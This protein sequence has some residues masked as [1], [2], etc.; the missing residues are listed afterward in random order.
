MGC[1]GGWET[2]PRL[3]PALHLNSTL[4]LAGVAESVTVTGESP[5]IDVKQNAAFATIQREA[6]E[7]MPKGRDFATI[8]R[9]APGAQSETKAGNCGDGCGVQIDGASGSEV[10]G[11]AL[12]EQDQSVGVGGAG[13]DG[14]EKSGSDPGGGDGSGGGSA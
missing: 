4:K 2:G 7:R 9:Q 5:I 10:A 13:D 1:V 14:S 11:V 12:D 8:L 6:I 3:A